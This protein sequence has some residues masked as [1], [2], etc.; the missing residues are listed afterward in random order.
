V[1]ENALLFASWKSLE[2]GV[3]SRGKQHS[4]VCMNME[5]ANHMKHC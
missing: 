4:D 3:Y 2:F 5:T 1:F